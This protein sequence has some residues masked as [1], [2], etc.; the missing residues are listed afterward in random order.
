MGDEILGR[1]GKSL[2]KISSGPKLILCLFSASP[3]D[4]SA[5]DITQNSLRFPTSAF[6]TINVQTTFLP[7]PADPWKVFVHSIPERKR[8]GA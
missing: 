2:P 6:P 3:G 4:P 7:E 8:S 1:F 5:Q